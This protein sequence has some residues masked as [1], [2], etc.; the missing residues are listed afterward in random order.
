MPRHRNDDEDDDDSGET[1]TQR[2]RTDRPG[3]PFGIAG[4]LRVASMAAWG[5]LL[6]VTVGAAVLFFM[7]LGR[8]NGAPQ[9]AALGAIFS[10]ILIAAYLTAR[11]VDRVAQRVIEMTGKPTAGGGGE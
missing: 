6:L 11:C 2:R 9:E 1:R 3:T 8:A 10:T 7:S 5:L 4:F